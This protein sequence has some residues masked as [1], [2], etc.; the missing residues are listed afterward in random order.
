MP[1]V[2]IPAHNEERG[3]PRLLTALAPP[4]GEAPLSIVV[5]AN[6]CTDSTAEV[7]RQFGIS[8]IETP[9]P[10]KI[11]ALALGDAEVSTYPRLYVDADVVIT[12]DD[13]HKLF[14]A[15]SQGV[16]AAGPARQFPMNS[17]SAL[18]RWYYSVWQELP[19]VKSELYGRGVIAVDAVGHTRLGDWKST[20][21]DD[22]LIAMSFAPSERVVAQ[23]AVAV[24]Y[25][26]KTYRDLVRR[27]VRAMTGNSQLASHPDAPRLRGSGASP[28]FLARLLRS[29]P[30]LLP[31]IVTFAFTAVVA[32]VRA[33]IAVSTGDTTWRRDESSRR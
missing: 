15:L 29:R 16:H 24:I 17:S 21:S 18:V 32:K 14:A 27:R 19:G 20:M 5:V 23:G 8:V 10:S 26:P 12:Y 28:R 33:T 22:L 31:G 4:P 3:L 2:V 11:R 7:A 9:I 6:G 1:G 30:E 25:P 13:A